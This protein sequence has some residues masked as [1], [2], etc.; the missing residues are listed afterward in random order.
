MECACLWI[1][2]IMLLMH[3]T[4]HLALY[5]DALLNDTAEEGTVRL[6]GGGTPL[7]GRVEVFLLDAWGTVCD[8]NWDLV[9]AT[10][11]CHQLGYL[12]AVGAPRSAAFGAGSGPSWYSNVR[13]AGTEKNLTECSKSY[14]SQGS[15]C[16]HSQDAGVVCSSESNIMSGLHSFIFL[17][18]QVLAFK[19]RY[20]VCEYVRIVTSKYNTQHQLTS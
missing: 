4:L 12:R 7:E 8:Y 2:Y 18:D 6:I 3:C 19:M 14:S 13:C 5:T 16:L 15:A 11:V 9:D 20:E 17:Q 10:V 1:T